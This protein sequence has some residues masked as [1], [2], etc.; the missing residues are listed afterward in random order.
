MH[1]D[2]VTLGADAEEFAFDG[3]EVVFRDSSFLAKT[4]SSASASRSRGPRRSAGVS[5]MPSGIQTLVTAG[6]PS[7]LPMAAPISRAGLAVLDPEAADRLVRMGER[8]TAGGLADARSR[9]D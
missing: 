7:A 3:V 6:V 5:F 4:V 8:E 9:W 1:A 2:R